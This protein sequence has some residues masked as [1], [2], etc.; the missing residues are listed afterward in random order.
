MTLRMMGTS[1][2]RASPIGL[3][4]RSLTGGPCHDGCPVPSSGA[5]CTVSSGIHE[6]LLDYLKENPAEDLSV[7][8]KAASTAREVFDCAPFTADYPIPEH[9]AM[10]YLCGRSLQSAGGFPFKASYNLRKDLGRISIS[11]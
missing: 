1:K 2:E 7:L 11:Q 10:Y 3:G 8:V 5:C 6:D 4:A 9:G